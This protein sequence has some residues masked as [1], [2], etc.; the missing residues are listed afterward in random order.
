LEALRAVAATAGANAVLGVRL[1][2]ASTC[3]GTGVDVDAY[4]TAVT[5]EPQAD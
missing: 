3:E 4:G 2:S 1:D 5:V